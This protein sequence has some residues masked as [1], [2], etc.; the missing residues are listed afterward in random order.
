MAIN[1]DLSLAVGEIISDF[2]ETV[3]IYGNSPGQVFSG[4]AFV[5]GGGNEFEVVTG[6][7]YDKDAFTI[8]VNKVDITF[9]PEPGMLVNARGKD[10]RIARD[11]VDNKRAHYRLSVVGRD[12]P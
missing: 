12:V 6:G 3:Q 7:Y 2:G 10:L 1:T 4:N 8:S 11:G 5:S 9:T